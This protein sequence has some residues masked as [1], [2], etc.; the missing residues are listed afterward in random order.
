MC[1]ACRPQI[2]T[3]HQLQ[4]LLHDLINQ[5]TL[6]LLEFLIGQ[7]ALLAQQDQALLPLSQL[8]PSFSLSNQSSLFFCLFLV[9]QSLLNTP[10]FQKALILRVPFFL[11]S[12][13]PQLFLEFYVSYNIGTKS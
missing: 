5:N 10:H 11:E 12:G 1:L 8:V 3:S 6:L 13:L 7:A 9:Q 2:L 4:T